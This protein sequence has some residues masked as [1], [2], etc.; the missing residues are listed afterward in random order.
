MSHYVFGSSLSYTDY[1]QARSFENSFRSE[2]RGQTRAIIATVDQLRESNI[3]IVRGAK[4]AIAGESGRLSTVVSQGFSQVSE[5]LRYLSSAMS[6]GFDRV[7]GEL[8]DV[9]R[10]IRELSSTFEWGF[11]QLLVS[12]GTANDSLQE[13]VR[14]SKTPAQTWAYEQFDIARDAFRKDLFEEALRYVNHAVS[15][16]GGNTG[17]ALEHR[18]HILLGTLRIGST[19]NTSDAVV[20]LPLAEQAFANAARYARR[21][22]PREAARAYLAAGWASYC[23]GDMKA[24]RQHTEAATALVPDLAEAQFQLG[25]I[26]MHLGESAAAMQPLRRAVVLDKGYA[27]KAAGDGDYQKHQKRVDSVLNE[28]RLDAGDTAV[29]AIQ[30]ASA[31]CASTASIAVDGF[32]LSPQPGIATAARL[33]TEARVAAETHTYF[34]Y[35]EAQAKCEEVLRSLRECVREFASKGIRECDDAIRAL[36]VQI[37]ARRL[38]S[39]PDDRLYWLVWLVGVVI[40][41][42]LAI[43]NCNVGGNWARQD[44]GP[45]KGLGQLI[46]TMIAGLFLTAAVA[47]AVKQLTD[48]AERGRRE[49]D[50]LELQSKESAMTATRDRLAGML[51]SPPSWLRA[52]PPPVPTRQVSNL[53]RENGFI[54]VDFGFS[55]DLLVAAL[56]PEATGDTDLYIGIETDLGEREVRARI[57][58]LKVGSVN[59]IPGFK[60]RRTYG[61]NLQLLI[62]SPRGLPSGERAHYLIVEK[63][64]PYWL[65][66][67]REKVVAI[68]GAQDSR[69]SVTLFVVPKNDN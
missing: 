38:P 25:K 39:S 26:L 12:L 21:D 20:N 44:Y 7:A 5:E 22:H 54:C 24:A 17:Y 65:N 27:L 62:R 52:Q 18:F 10:G 8:R 42:V 41:W 67:V 47:S 32:A 58:L 57:D 14:I 46:V 15:G 37:S 13:L 3:E 11:S 60:V 43:E 49:L 33:L 64:G 6:E 45:F 50:I 66:V 1:L 51:D 4:S 28:L 23:Q 59:D 61:L 55:G 69:L 31:A 19:S 48:G 36:Q 53:R 29:R 30:A 2:V 40:A 16:F 56:P 34:G 63:S 68:S 35:L 9:S